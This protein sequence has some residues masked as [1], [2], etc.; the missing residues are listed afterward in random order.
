KVEGANVDRHLD[1]TVHNEQCMPAETPP[2]PYIDNMALGATSPCN[3]APPKDYANQVK[4]KCKPPPTSRVRRGF[5]GGKLVDS[6]KPG[7]HQNNSKA[8]CEARKCMLVQQTPNSCK[9]C[10]KTPHHIIPSA[11][12]VAH[13]DRGSGSASSIGNYSTAKAPCICADGK[14]HDAYQ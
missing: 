13:A 5:S 9:G 7:P 4:D 6:P 3:K 2:W 11:E 8:C 14:D 10:G 1:M 12:F